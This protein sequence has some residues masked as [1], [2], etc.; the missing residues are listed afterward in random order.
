MAQRLIAEGNEEVV[1]VLFDTFCA[2]EV[3]PNDSNGS[4]HGTEA[5]RKNLSKA[6]QKLAQTPA[7]KKWQWVTR[8]MVT[9]KDGLQRRAAHLMLP[10]SL[11]NVR[12]AC[13]EAAKSYVPRAYPGRLIL[14][15]S[16]HK[17]LLQLREPHAAWS[18][19]AEQGL[20][21]HEVEG[22]HDNILLEPQVRTVAQELKGYLKAAA[23]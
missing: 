12:R 16:R 11:K 22:N 19:Y 7:S 21:I 1:V 6:W 20:E 3:N 10:R 23:E 8:G 5:F 4:K 17:P 9:V 18:R 13:E 2:P 14:F 15:R